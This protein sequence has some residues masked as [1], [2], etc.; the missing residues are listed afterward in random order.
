V[1]IPYEEVDVYYLGSRSKVSGV[2]YRHRLGV[3]NL[4][5]PKEY[6]LTSLADCVRAAEKMSW[7]SEGFVVVDGYGNRVKIK[8]PAYVMAHFARN[9]NVI[10][11]KH[12]LRIILENE[13]DEFLCYASD[14]AM[15]LT[16]ILNEMQ[17]YKATCEY[18]ARAL[19][20]AA[21]HLN[22]KD[23]ATLVMA[24]PKIYWEYLFKNYECLTSVE[25]YTK[26]W[27]YHRWDRTLEEA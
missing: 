2:E 21:G 26:D 6:P 24:L 14:Y 17:T 20:A 10:T 9:N 5:I 8:S 18:W 15:E 13:V 22:R 4:P 12:L 16:N 23:Y 7:D 11:R 1:V 3:S 25:E 27:D 19:V